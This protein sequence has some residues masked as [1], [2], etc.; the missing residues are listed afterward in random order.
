MAS[1]AQ[2]LIV[3][4]IDLNSLIIA[5]TERPDITEILNIFKDNEDLSIREYLTIKEF[6]DYI[7]AS[8]SYVRNL[9]KHAEKNK[10]FSVIKVG[11]EYRLDRLSYEKWVRNGGK[12]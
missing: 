9:A 3:R 2:K 5:L 12:F 1:E 7:R 8:Q 4:N 11:R 6:A 10:L